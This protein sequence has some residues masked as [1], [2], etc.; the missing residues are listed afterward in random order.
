MDHDFESPLHGAAAAGELEVV[1]CLFKEDAKLNLRDSMGRT[2]LARATKIRDTKMV[3]LLLSYRNQNGKT[4]TGSEQGD[5][6]PHTIA[7]RFSKFAEPALSE[8]SEEK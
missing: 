8:S 4:V 2:P 7:L 5:T 3:K 6:P 1:E